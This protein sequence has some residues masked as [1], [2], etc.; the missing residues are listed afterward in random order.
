MP[1]PPQVPDV[2]FSRFLAMA[3]AH[4]R[5]YS[6]WSMRASLPAAV[7]VIVAPALFGQSTTAH[8]SPDRAL[9]AMITNNATGESLT[10]VR[11]VQERV[12]LSRDERS[13]D[14]THGGRVDHA[15]W[16]VD[17]QFFVANT[18]ATGGHQPWAR[19]I[20]F[21]SRAKNHI[22]ELSKAGASATGDFT[23][24]RPDIVETAI[25]CFDGGKSRRIIIRLRSVESTGRLSVAPC[26]GR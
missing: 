7:W 13:A 11:D 12:L 22:F 19:P 4:S 14:G 24:K 1:Y 18:S 25:T 21:Y 26:V 16:T 8:T 17:S 2:R 5:R 10:E 23:L 20:W 6:L 9:R 3:L 15:E